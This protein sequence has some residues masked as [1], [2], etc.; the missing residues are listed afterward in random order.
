VIH[1]ALGDAIGGAVWDGPNDIVLDSEQSGLR[2]IVR[3][4]ADGTGV[5]Q[6]T[7]GA[8]SQD[9]P[10]ISADRA[11]IVYGDSTGE[12]DLGIHEA[13]AD[14]SNVHVLTAASPVGSKSGDDDP[15]FSPDGTLIAYNHI[16][17][18]DK[19]L[20]ELWVMRA[21]GT[22]PRRLTDS[23]TGAS[24]PHWSPDGTRILFTQHDDG[25]GQSLREP[26][27]IIDLAGG[28]PRP[29]TDPKDPGESWEGKWSPDGT[30]IVFKYHVSGWDHNELRLVNADGTDT[31]TL[32]VSPALGSAE[33]PDWSV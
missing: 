11:L 31:R 7:S 32:W 22:Q 1:S 13:N 5:T 33:S 14:G 27:W 26:L 20:S 21:D 24:H 16:V 23:S 15:E 28:S 29:L 12:R 9:L 3:I 6:L 30:Q 2:H 18:G 10:A 8:D 25:P 17:D 19:G 4:N